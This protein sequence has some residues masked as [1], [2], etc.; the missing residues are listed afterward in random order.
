M[1]LSGAMGEYVSV[2]PFSNI[3]VIGAWILEAQREML[4]RPTR[5]YYIRT[6]N[7]T[8]GEFLKIR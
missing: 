5:V 2:Y 8:N 6:V 4:R 1:S 3:D 7:D